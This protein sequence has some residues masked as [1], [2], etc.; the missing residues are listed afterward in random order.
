MPIDCEVILRWDAMP[1]QRR[2]LG[3]A[4]WNWCTRAAGGKGIYRYLDNQGLADLM[5]GGFPASSERSSDD[6]LPYVY[7]TI[8]GNP[9][10]DRAD[11]LES[12]RHAIPRQGVSDIRISGES[13]IKPNANESSTQFWE[14]LHG[15]WN[16]T[17][18][19]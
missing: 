17:A 11:L 7:F 15:T 14:P 19:R 1:T 3:H 12:L 5:A 4:L 2:T 8:P 10:S 6:R 9:E 18:K 16:V 13:W